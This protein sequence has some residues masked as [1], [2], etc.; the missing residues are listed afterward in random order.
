MRRV[1]QRGSI[2][3]LHL[4]PDRVPLL[5]VNRVGDRSLVGELDDVLQCRAAHAELGAGEHQRESRVE[6][7]AIEG[8]VRELGRELSV[9]GPA[10]RKDSIVGDERIIDNDRVAAR[11]SLTVG[12]WLERWLVSRAAPR[13]STLRGYAAHVR[14]YLA[15]CLGQILLISY[16]R[17][18]RRCSPRLPA[19]SF[20]FL[21]EERG[22]TMARPASRISNVVM[23]GPL[24]PFAERSGTRRVI[25]AGQHAYGGHPQLASAYPVAAAA[26]AISSRL[27]PRSCSPFPPSLTQSARAAGRSSHRILDRLCADACSPGCIAV[28]VMSG[29]GASELSD[30]EFDALVVMTR[31]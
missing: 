13:N 27:R 26:A 21:P 20:P 7:R 23:P 6:G 30:K 8:L 16:R 5:R 10:H 12:Q 3:D 17:M 18:H 9:D 25:L 24:A 29:A 28:A 2:G 11:S 4:E 19:S 1:D 31:A 14:P 15:P 22:R